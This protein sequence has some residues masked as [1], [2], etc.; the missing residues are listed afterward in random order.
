MAVKLWNGVITP[1]YYPHQ[2]VSLPFFS[3]PSLPFTLSSPALGRLL[4]RTYSS[5]ARWREA[6]IKRATITGQSRY[7]VRMAGTFSDMSTEEGHHALE[8]QSRF[9]WLFCRSLMTN[10]PDRT[11]MNHARTSSERSFV[12]SWTLLRF[13]VCYRQPTVPRLPCAK[14]P[15]L[16]T[17]CR[18]T[19]S[20]DL[21]LTGPL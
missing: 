12:A 9:T 10:N 11:I 8:R 5:Y 1:Y 4:V 7:I 19:K 3:L 21:R 14:H 16:W 20:C 6:G 2:G 18:L 17:R 15:W 13:P